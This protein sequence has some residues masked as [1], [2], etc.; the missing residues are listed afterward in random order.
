MSTLVDHEIASWA[1]KGG[2]Q[3]FDLEMVNPATINLRVGNSAKI[4][5][6]WGLIDVDLGKYSER[7]PYVVPPRGW[8]LTSTLEWVAIPTD[9]AGEVMLRSSAARR[10]WDHHKA[11]FIDP[12]W[13]GILT[14]EFVNCL[15]M[16]G[17]PIY[18]GL[19]LVQ[20]KLEMLQSTPSKNYRETGRYHG[21]TTV[22]QCKDD[23][24]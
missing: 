22:E 16:T 4:E 20:M 14:L 17:L 19:E 5:G 3:P 12:G 7:L 21:A 1:H 10:G 6:P 18:P 11:G 13:N 9:M 15:G 24:L 2:V 8:I 23:R